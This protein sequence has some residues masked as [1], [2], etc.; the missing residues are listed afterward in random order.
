MYKIILSSKAKKFLKKLDKA[1]KQRIVLALKRLR[2][3]PESHVTRYI[4]YP[5]YKFRV[6][7]YR[8]ILRIEKNVLLV[9]VIRI[10]HRKK[11]YKK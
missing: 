7:D 11:V 4:G 6:G 8:I 1:S 9:M 10:D 5:G 3:R 2:F